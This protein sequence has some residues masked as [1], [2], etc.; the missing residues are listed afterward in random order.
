MTRKARARSHTDKARE[1]RITWEI[2]VDAYTPIEQAMGWYYYLEDALKF[3]FTARC[4]AERAISPLKKGD[5]VE[6][7]GMA[8]EEECEH[9]MFVLIRWERHGLAVP[10]SQLEG[11]HVGEQDRQAIEDWHYWVKQGYEL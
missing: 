6:V 2:L 4:V 7:I 9:E 5:E 1:K 10:L 11:L 8:P 3:P